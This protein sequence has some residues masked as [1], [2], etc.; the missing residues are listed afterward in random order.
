MK[1]QAIFFNLKKNIKNSSADFS[2]K[3]QAIK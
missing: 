2:E 3:E 1:L